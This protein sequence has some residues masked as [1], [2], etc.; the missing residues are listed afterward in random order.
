MIGISV[1]GGDARRG[2]NGLFIDLVV[3][4]MSSNSV[5]LAAV[6]GPDVDP[7]IPSN[8]FPQKTS[9][10][11]S[12]WQTQVA[13][14]SSCIPKTEVFVSASRMGW[15]SAVRRIGCRATPREIE[16]LARK[17]TKGGAQPTRI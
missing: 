9:D 5:D 16:R 13:A 7:Y 15:A 8:A 17:R 4:A 11:R 10:Y 3:V 1:A 14:D 12:N 2:P 6:F